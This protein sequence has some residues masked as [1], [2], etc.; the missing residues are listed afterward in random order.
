LSTPISTAVRGRHDEVGTVPHERVSPGR[1][2]RRLLH[3][4]AEASDEVAAEV[5]DGGQAAARAVVGRL[6]PAA[7]GSQP[8]ER[9]V[10]RVVVE[11]GEVPGAHGLPQ[12]V[13]IE[14]GQ[15]EA[16]GDDAVLHVVHGVRHVVGE[17]HH[18]RLHARAR[19]LDA[20]AHPVEDRTV[21]VVGAELH[22]DP[23]RAVG[24]DPVGSGRL[25]AR[26]GV[27]RAGVQGRPGEV[28][29]G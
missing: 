25:R 9:L 18:L 19:P 11:P 13:A 5:L 2:E 16:S 8:G 28:E 27:L 15:V 17:V 26:P 7:D 12:A 6:R 21:V 3:A 23:G 14:P 20:G 22:H 4:A 10:E 1:R 29:A 24:V